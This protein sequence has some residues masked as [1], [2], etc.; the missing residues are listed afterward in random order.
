VTSQASRLHVV[1][2]AHC[3][4]KVIA[5]TV[6]ALLTRFPDVIVVDDNSQDDTAAL[7]SRAGA[8]VLRHPVNLGQ[9]AALQTG[10]AYALDRGAAYIATFDADGQHRPADLQAMF[11]VLLKERVDIVLGSRFLG[12]CEQIPLSRLVFLK[13]AILFSQA[14]TGLRLSDTHNG[15]R[16]MT[17][18][19][20]RRLD[21]RQNRMA[22]A[23]EILEA[24]ARCRLSY[25]EVPVTIRYSD[26]SLGKGQKLTGTVNILVDLMIAWLRR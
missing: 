10:I 3:E 11:S 19:A 18:D 21:I 25:R 17:A 12:E 15:L 20:A 7:A 1:V 24:V 22:H 26:Y 14:T 9:G 4:A 23:S 16:V 6:A 8:T 2:P 5:D 13:A